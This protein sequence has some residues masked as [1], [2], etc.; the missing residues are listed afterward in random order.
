LSIIIAVTGLTV[1]ASLDTC[2]PVSGEKFGPAAV[3]VC[4]AEVR[5]DWLPFVEGVTPLVEVLA[6]MLLAV[7]VDASTAVSVVVPAEAAVREKTK[8]Q[9]TAAKATLMDR[10]AVGLASVLRWSRAR[11]CSI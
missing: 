3:E 1:S 6:S 7:V 5:V 8:A 11:S 9:A 2:S 4:V 10:P